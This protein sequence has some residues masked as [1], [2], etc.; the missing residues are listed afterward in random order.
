M[1]YYIQSWILPYWQHRG[2]LIVVWATLMWGERLY[3]WPVCQSSIDAD[4]I[5]RLLRWLGLELSL[6]LHLS[7]SENFPGGAWNL[8]PTLFFRM[9]RPTE[10]KQSITS[11]ESDAKQVDC[12]PDDGQNSYGGRFVHGI[13]IAILYHCLNGFHQQ[14][15][16]QGCQKQKIDNHGQH[17]QTGLHH[18]QSHSITHYP[19]LVFPSCFCN[20]PVLL[21]FNHLK[22]IKLTWFYTVAWLIKILPVLKIGWLPNPK[23][24]KASWA[25]NNDG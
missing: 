4:R 12:N 20:E 7:V 25:I 11:D 6:L 1:G 21:Y 9:I 14:W 8:F 16:I 10:A 13:F 19:S 18:E 5:W 15:K 2:K 24:D 22:N 23:L 3:R 17:L